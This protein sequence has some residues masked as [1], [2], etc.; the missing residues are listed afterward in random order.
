[1]RRILD[2]ILQSLLTIVFSGLLLIFLIA[3]FCI[4]VVGGFT[5]GCWQDIAVL[6]L[7]RLEYKEDV[8]TM[9]ATS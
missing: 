2:N 8:Q 5:I 3:C 4:G 7:N 6:D 9:A 1:M